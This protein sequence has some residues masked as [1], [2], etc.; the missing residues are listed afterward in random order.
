MHGIQRRLTA[1]YTPE[2]NGV[3]EQMNRTLIEM[4]RYILLQG[5]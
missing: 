3:A 5:N 1:P 2:Q 4:A